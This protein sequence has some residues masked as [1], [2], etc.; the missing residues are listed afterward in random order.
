MNDDKP[1]EVVGHIKQAVYDW[2]KD[3]SGQCKVHILGVSYKP[4]V[5]DLR[6]SPALKI[7]RSMAQDTTMRITVTDPHVDGAQ[8]KHYF[9]DAVVSMID[10]LEH[11]DIVVFLVA[12]D[13][14]KLIDRKILL[15]K[16]IL[17][18]CGVL[19]EAN[20]GANEDEIFWSARSMMDFFIANQQ[21]EDIDAA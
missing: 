2:Q 8:L 12:H 16:K 21:G 19:Y 18:F 17:D 14:F 13:R 5:E 4:N 3:N 9:G 7:T 1:E 15:S 20:T 10:G 6:E 11:S